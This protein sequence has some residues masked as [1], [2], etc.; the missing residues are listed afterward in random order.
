MKEESHEKKIKAKRR[1]NTVYM[2]KQRNEENKK[3]H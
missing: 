1:R 3:K 2:E